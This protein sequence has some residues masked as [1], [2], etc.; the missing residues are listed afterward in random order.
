[1]SRKFHSDPVL[2]TVTR[3]LL[4]D[5]RLLWM[6]KPSIKRL[7]S[8]PTEGID[9]LS[10][11]ILGFIIAI[12]MGLV[13]IS[14]NSDSPVALSVLLVLMLVGA[15]VIP[16]LGQAIQAR[17]TLYAITTFRALIIEGQRV[18]SYGAGDITCLE[19][20]RINAKIGDVIFK[21]IVHEHWIPNGYMPMPTKYIEEIGFFGIEKADYVK[22]TLLDALRNSP[23]SIWEEDKSIVSD[24]QERK[25]MAHS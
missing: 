1:M 3:H 8:R 9:P 6:G 19:Y 23:Y 15:A 24:M 13:L 10:I 17:N 16:A 2:T 22:M 12:L 4:E 5:E 21:E 14:G 20:R 11:L 18:S 7:L 25:A